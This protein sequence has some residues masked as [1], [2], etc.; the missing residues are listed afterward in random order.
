MADS[1]PATPNSSS[2]RGLRKKEDTLTML[3]FN[4]VVIIA[5]DNSEKAGLFAGKRKS[6]RTMRV[7]QEAEGGIGKVAE[8]KDWSGW[9]GESESGLPTGLIANQQVILPCSQ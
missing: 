4:D 7:L 2:I 9:Q 3:I 8:V 6:D 1:R 5:Q